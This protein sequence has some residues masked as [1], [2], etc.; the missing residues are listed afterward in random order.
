MASKRFPGRPMALI[1]GIP[2][3]QRVW[4]QAIMSKIGEV[5]VACSE[6]EVFDLIKSLGGNAVM[7][8]PELPSGTDRIYAGY[9]RSCTLSSTRKYYKFTR[10]YAAHNSQKIS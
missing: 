7:T 3:I 2:M 4:E 6:V 10:R 8:S 5:I 1:N 9:Q